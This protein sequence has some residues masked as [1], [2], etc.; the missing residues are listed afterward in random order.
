[1]GGAASAP[2]GGEDGRGA[3][4]VD[5]QGGWIAGEPVVGREG[6][7]TPAYERV[8][9]TEDRCGIGRPMRRDRQGEGDA[10]VIIGVKFAR[11]WHRG[12]ARLETAG[13]VPGSLFSR[14]KQASKGTVHG[15]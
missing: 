15:G 3:D 14:R 1:M 12:D 11:S 7:R 2:L 4:D 5:D 13:T 10:R 8:L 9:T 6:G